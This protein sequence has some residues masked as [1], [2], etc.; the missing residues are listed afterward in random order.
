MPLFGSLHQ[1][2]SYFDA[3]RH[4]VKIGFRFSPK[5]LL[6]AQVKGPRRSINWVVSVTDKFVQ[7][8]L[9]EQEHCLPYRFPGFIVR[10]GHALKV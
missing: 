3:I 4:A 6:K 9:L 5:Q 7:A 2:A 8:L 1:L 10:V